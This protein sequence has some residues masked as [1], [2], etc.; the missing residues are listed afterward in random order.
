M[1]N[2]RGE[3]ISA[4]KMSDDAVC[5]PNHAASRVHLHLCR[6]AWDDRMEIVN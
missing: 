3:P 4:K 6:Q 1:P 5:H 2:M